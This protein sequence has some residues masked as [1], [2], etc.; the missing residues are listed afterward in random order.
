MLFLDSSFFW[1]SDVLDLL[2]VSFGQSL[3]W[4]LPSSEGEETSNQALPSKGVF[5]IFFSVTFRLFSVVFLT[6]FQMIFCVSFSPMSLYEIY[7]INLPQH[8]IPILLSLFPSH[9]PMELPGIYLN[10]W[11]LF[12][13]FFSIFILSPVELAQQ[14][15]LGLAA[16]WCPLSSF[17]R[18]DTSPQCR[19]SGRG[20]FVCG[21]LY[22]LQSFA[23]SENQT[24]SNKTTK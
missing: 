2:L 11:Y 23:D 8:S 18:A 14:T 5:W 22:E 16:N 19:H 9:T 17:Q 12:C 10:L 7:F 24:K 3:H 15:C 21:F 20:I 4:R 6:S 1:D 13:F